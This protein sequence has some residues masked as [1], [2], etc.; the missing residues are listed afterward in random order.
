VMGARGRGVKPITPA[1]A[2][3]I[4]YPEDVVWRRLRSTGCRRSS[5]PKGVMR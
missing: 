5:R 1:A 4:N 2:G 3:K